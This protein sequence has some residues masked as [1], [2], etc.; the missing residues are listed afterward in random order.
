[1]MSKRTK[2]SQPYYPGQKNTILPR[3]NNKKVQPE[4]VR[5]AFVKV[6]VVLG[7]QTVQLDLTARID[8]PEPVLE[9]KDV[10]KNIKITQCRLLLPTNKLFLKGFVRKNIQYATPVRSDYKR[11]VSDL[12][13]MTLDVPFETVT[14][15]DFINPPQFETNPGRREFTYFSESKLPEGFAQKD[16]LLSAEFSEFDQISGEHFNELPY[17][18]LI[19]SQFVEY[20]EAL[21]RQMGKVRDGRGQSMN[22]PFEEGTFTEMQEKM[23]VE[24][25]FKVLQLQQVKVNDNHK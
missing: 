23:V 15:I 13:S 24:L 2:P 5:E 21:N 17:C 1:M 7:E 9:I 10:K 16:K 3:S 19:S 25:T 11:V 14:D 8:F 6:P 4:A 18:E 20:D 12:R 22:A